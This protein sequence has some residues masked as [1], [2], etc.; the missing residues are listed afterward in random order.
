[1]GETGP[2]FSQN[3]VQASTNIVWPIGEVITYQDPYYR[4][5]NNEEYTDLSEMG[6]DFKK[7]A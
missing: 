1:M 6:K 4:A 7:K 2:D 5:E 3:W